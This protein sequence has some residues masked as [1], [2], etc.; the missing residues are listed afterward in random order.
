MTL[1]VGSSFDRLDFHIRIWLFWVSDPDSVTAAADS[2]SVALSCRSEFRLLWLQIRIQLH[3]AADPDPVPLVGDPY[4]VT[5][6]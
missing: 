6:G 3:W 5:L 2:D 4:S 1:C